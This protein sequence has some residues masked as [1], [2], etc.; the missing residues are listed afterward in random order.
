[1]GSSEAIRFEQL[2][3]RILPSRSDC[4]DEHK[5]NKGYSRN[6]ENR[7]KHLFLLVDQSH[8]KEDAEKRSHGPEYA[9]NLWHRRRLRLEPHL[10]GF[11]HFHKSSR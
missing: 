3:V 10:G 11:A 1:M 7:T 2:P 8:S 4:P 6:Q 5:H 9:D